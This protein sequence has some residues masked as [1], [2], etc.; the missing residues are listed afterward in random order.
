M[1]LF[2]IELALARPLE[3]LDVIGTPRLLLLDITS[4][5]LLLLDGIG[6]P[7]SLVNLL[8]ES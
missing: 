1:R 5:P 8:A 3:L 4:P 7:L 6:A 2:R